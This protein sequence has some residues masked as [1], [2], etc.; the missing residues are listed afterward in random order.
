MKRKTKRILIFSA[1]LTT[2]LVFILFAGGLW[3]ASNQLLSPSFKGLSKDLSVCKPKTAKFLGENCGNLRITHQFKFNEVRIP[4]VNGF[5]LPGWLIKTADNGMERSRAAIM[6]VP[7]GGSDRRE[8]TRYIQFLLNQKLD[9]LTFDLECQGEAPCPVPGVTYGHRESRDVLSAYLYLSDKYE[10]VYAMGSSVGAASIL[11][12][13]PQMPKLAGVIAENP[14]PSFQRLIKEAPESQS[15]PAWATNLLISLTMIRGRFDGMLGPEHSLRFAGK[16]PILFIH[17][18]EDKVV[19]YP[20][21]QELADMYP[22][23]KTVWF[24]EK[25][26]HAAIW[27]VDHSQYEKRVA[28]FLTSMK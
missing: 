18:K 22:G 17:S 25:G 19:A 23:P 11:I 26:E 7:A 1:S 4:T 10:T 21:T 9:V 24:A 14:S 20:R 8:E 5:D 13:L 12:A 3:F 28:D 2:V 6:L 15:M 27:D 16:T